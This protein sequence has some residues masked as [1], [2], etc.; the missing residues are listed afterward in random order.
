LPTEFLRDG[1]GR[2]PGDKKLSHYYGG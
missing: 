1:R 2:L